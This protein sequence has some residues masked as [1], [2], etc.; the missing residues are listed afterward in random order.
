M[1]QLNLVEQI[2]IYILFREIMPFMK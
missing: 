2:K 1:L